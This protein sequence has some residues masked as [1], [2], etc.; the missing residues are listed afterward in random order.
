M[1]R[2]RITE[3]FDLTREVIEI[4]EAPRRSSEMAIETLARLIAI[5]HRTGHTISSP[6]PYVGLASKDES[7]IAA[8][9]DKHVNHDV[10]STSGM[11]ASG[12]ADMLREDIVT[13]LSDR[14]DGVALLAEGLNSPGA[15]GR[16]HEFVRLFERA[17][18][19]KAG[20]LASFLSS[21]LTDDACPHGF[22]K[23]EVH[24]WIEARPKVAH[25][26]RRPEFL[27]EADVRP[28]IRRMEEA[29]Y[30]VLLNKAAWQADSTDRRELWRS[31][32]GS[33]DRDSGV[34]VSHSRTATLSVQILDGF[35]AYPL[36]LA[37]SMEHTLPRGV[38]L[39]GDVHGG[40]LRRN[41]AADSAE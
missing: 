33:L 10:T 4:P 8:L 19:R 12:T 32:A 7:T 29:A 24:A 25:A 21:F 40:V 18:G 41:D 1:A 36:M 30:E 3:P 20:A 5:E 35:K 26:D 22:T 6:M 31:T 37:G 39:Q 2:T 9:A 23:S 28:W 38:W 27:L 13:G 11:T 34:F 17:F 15:L 14:I 16:Y